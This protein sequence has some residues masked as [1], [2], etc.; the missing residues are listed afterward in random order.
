MQAGGREEK[1]ERAAVACTS[2]A[3]PSARARARGEDLE[4]TETGGGELVWAV[5]GGRP[6]LGV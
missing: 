6:P 3:T 4:N 2:L 1:A 5:R